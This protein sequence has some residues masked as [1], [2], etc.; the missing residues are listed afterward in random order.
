MVSENEIKIN[1][2]GLSKPGP[3]LMVEAALEKDSYE[4]MRVVVSNPEAASD[5]EAF[6]RERNAIVEVDLI[7]EEFHI[8]ADFSSQATE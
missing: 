5:L 6:F 4:M 2:R 7:G 3:R 8:L 1:A